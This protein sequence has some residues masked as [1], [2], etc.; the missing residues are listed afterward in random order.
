MKFGEFF[1]IRPLFLAI[2]AKDTARLNGSVKKIYSRCLILFSKQ[3][4]CWKGRFPD[5][6][7][8]VNG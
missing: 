7:S 4:S 8:T 5:F 3:T 1:L 6:L 2:V